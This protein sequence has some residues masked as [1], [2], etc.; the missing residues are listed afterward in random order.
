MSRFGEAFGQQ[1]D[2]CVRLREVLHAYDVRQLPV[3][4]LQNAD[5]AG[6]RRAHFLVDRRDHRVIHY[7]DSAAAGGGDGMAGYLGPALLCF[8][9]AVFSDADFAAIRRIG[10]SRKLSDASVT[11][12]TGRFGVGFN[13]VFHITDLPIIVSRTSA[14]WFD[15][16]ATIL[17]GVSRGEPGALVDW[18]T[19]AGRAT[20]AAHPAQ[21]APLQA[22]PFGCTPGSGVF[23]GSLFRLPLRTEAQAASSRLS[24]AHHSGDSI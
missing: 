14:V 24:S 1:V 8:N 9:D 23:P 7:G 12:K 18:S 10:D 17:P 4:L 15:P 3:E 13:S 6:A 22:A 5:D 11:V 20:V 19:A 16:H 21:F 2:L